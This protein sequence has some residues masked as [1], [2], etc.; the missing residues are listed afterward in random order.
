[1]Q[2]DDIIHLQTIDLNLE[3]FYAGFVRIHFDALDHHQETTA[4]V[5]TV[6][7]QK[8]REILCVHLVFFREFLPKM[9]QRYGTVDGRNPAPPEMDKTL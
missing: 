5:A 7:L 4:F 1:M 3:I 8:I 6:E 2:V 9:P